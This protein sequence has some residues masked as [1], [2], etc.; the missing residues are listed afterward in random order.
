M[1]KEIAESKRR[2]PSRMKAV[3]IG[4]VLGAAWGAVM[5]GIFV[6]TGKSANTGILAYLMLSTAMIGGGVAAFFGAADARKR[7]E[8]LTPKLR[9]KK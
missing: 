8:R 9:K 7:G 5:W 6:A 1:A 4:V 2:P 3:G